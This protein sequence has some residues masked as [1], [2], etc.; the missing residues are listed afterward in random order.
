MVT[1]SPNM[2]DDVRTDVVMTV[3]DADNAIVVIDDEVAPAPFD[4]SELE[5]DIDCVI[6][7]ERMV[8]KKSDHDTEGGPIAAMA[9]LTT[10]DDDAIIDDEVAPAPFEPLELEDD[11]EGAITTKRMVAKK[12]DRVIERGTIA[13]MTLLTTIDDEVA[14]AP[15]DPS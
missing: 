4:P 9:F 13:A 6:N 5:D 2:T 12:S 7:T 14:P 15:F 1:D 8:A 10:I 11:I 3:D